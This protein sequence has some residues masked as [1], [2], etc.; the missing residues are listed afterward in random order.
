[1]PC[2]WTLTTKNTTLK[3]LFCRTSNVH[4][5]SKQFYPNLKLSYKQIDLVVT[6]APFCCDIVICIILLSA[7]NGLI[8]VLDSGIEVPGS[9]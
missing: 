8:S 4:C 7:N 6:I 3:F 9:V 5:S 2:T 1:M